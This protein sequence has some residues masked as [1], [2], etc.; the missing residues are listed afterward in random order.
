MLL[1]NPVLPEE[2]GEGDTKKKE[3]KKTEAG[4]LLGFF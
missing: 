3:D 1:P 2:D 4:G